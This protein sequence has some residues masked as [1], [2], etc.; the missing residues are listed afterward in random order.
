[1]FRVDP[2]VDT[3]FTQFYLLTITLLYILINSLN[4]QL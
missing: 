1:M 4:I 3:L 2:Y